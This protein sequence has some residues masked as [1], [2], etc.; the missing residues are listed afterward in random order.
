M[1]Q[2]KSRRQPNWIAVAQQNPANCNELQV[3]GKVD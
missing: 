1:A 3:Y 2:S